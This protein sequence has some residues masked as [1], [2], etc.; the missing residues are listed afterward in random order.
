MRRAFAVVGVF[1]TVLVGSACDYHVLSGPFSPS[2]TESTLSVHTTNARTKANV[3][4]TTVRAN[5]DWPRRW[6]HPLVRNC[7]TDVTGHCSI[8]SVP[9]TTVSITVTHPEYVEATR[10]M[11]VLRGYV[12]FASFELEPK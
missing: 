7:V 6:S 11:A 2:E 10:D 5:G 4:G 9:L 1:F 3:G 12:N 8:R